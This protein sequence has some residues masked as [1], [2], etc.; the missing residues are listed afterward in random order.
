[1][2]NQHIHS[3]RFEV[4][5][6]ILTV[7]LL[8]IVI[9][10]IIFS[11]IDILKML[12][13][14]TYKYYEHRITQSAK[15]LEQKMVTGFSSE[16]SMS[17]L[18]NKVDY[19]YEISER[20]NSPLEMNIDIGV[21]LLEGMNNAGVSGAFILLNK[22]MSG[23]DLAGDKIFFLRDNN[24]NFNARN[25]ADIAVE[26]GSAKIASE[27][28][29]TLDSSW[30]PTLNA[31]NGGAVLVEIKNKLLENYR[32]SNI[33]EASKLGFWFP[34]VDLVGD[35]SDNIIYVEPIIDKYSGKFYGIYGIEVNK[36][37]LAESLDINSLSGEYETGFALLEDNLIIE[38][39]N[40][41]DKESEKREAYLAAY[42]GDYIEGLEEGRII[43]YFLDENEYVP[44]ANRNESFYCLGKEESGHCKFLGISRKIK[45]YD[46]D[47]YYHDKDWKLVLFLNTKNFRYYEEQYNYKI[48]LAFI[49]S[50]VL[51]LI[52]AL[53]ISSLITKPIRDVARNIENI[54]VNEKVKLKKTRI[55]EMNSLIEKIEASSENIGN[56]Y[57]RMQ[58]LLELI[59]FGIVIIE[60]DIEN[61]M[62]YKTGRM[63]VLFD[64]IDDDE[65]AIYQYERAD[66]DQVFR[67]MIKDKKI[68]ILDT[69][70]E[71]S[72]KVVR[73]EN[74]NTSKI[75]YINYE[76]RDIDGK[77][78]HI[79]SDYTDEYNE[80]LALEQEK[81]HDKL[82]SLINRDYFKRLV[83]AKLTDFP[84][85]Q[86]AMIMWDLDNLKF[87]NDSYGHD[88]G[89]LYLQEAARIISG[90]R[91]ENAYVSR[92]SGD[93]FFVF[94]EY[95]GDKNEVRKKINNLHET[96]LNSEL[97]L[98]MEES[99]K[100]R[101]SVGICWYPEDG[102]NYEELYKFSDFAM[103]RAKH[104][105]KGSIIEFERSIYDSE[106]IVITGKEAFNQ[107]IEKKLVRFAFQPIVSARTGEIFAY[108][109]LMRSI[110]DK[111]KSVGDVIKIAKVQF[112]LP[113][114]E[115]LTFENVFT[116]IE[117]NKEKIDDKK[118]FI[119]S[120]ANVV[121]PNDFE[122]TIK[123]KLSQ[124]GEQIVIEITESEEL[125]NQSMDIKKCY[126]RDF[127][128]LI[129]VDDFGSGYS[130]DRN[131]LRINPN[132]IKIDMSIVRD[133]DKD[134][135]RYQ[136][137]KNIIDYA[138]S[139]NIKTIAEGIENE[140][141]M[142]ALLELGADFLQGYYLAKPNLEII[143]LSQETKDEILAIKKELE[144]MM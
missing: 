50:I 61:N 112:K 47:S 35:H 77:H 8:Q 127:G 97:K 4:T 25:S 106:H 84:N 124:W 90:L 69:D 78:F 18:L 75:L 118:I 28:G 132:F 141:E 101:A 87:V 81:N 114:V 62:I 33:K 83:V 135:N 67:K 109:A 20:E 138:R 102:R 91:G 94:L 7:L 66:F 54:N 16:K 72:N 115:K 107:M 6:I 5:V 105:S 89:D 103:Y 39:D 17:S 63:S 74:L 53:I 144:S 71:S 12:E 30:Q 1:M 93:E 130:T 34:D 133:I 52:L 55:S 98:S 68:E 14:S 27:L 29:I 15:K 113:L 31:D 58:N 10:Y 45:L 104:T 57:F 100:I 51:A 108:E 120:I 24:V 22:E 59:G 136:L 41:N 80:I 116:A 88:W 99:I 65:P 110:S 43:Q 111:I 23:E 48:A 129:A 56:F 32:E 19:A 123:E 119:N 13:T 44:D 125:D 73:I 11:G 140:L 38:A 126:R 49:I 79:A 36:Q 128:N 9:F 46:K 122:T 37:M 85:S 40:I 76:E 137:V 92:F 70:Q 142:R 60:E 131:L 3:A 42:F 117:M 64:D 121:V 21:A 96:L 2:K 26:I 143:D 95:D 139:I 82:T 134:R 86:F